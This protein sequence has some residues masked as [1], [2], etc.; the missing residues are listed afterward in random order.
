[1]C[2]GLGKSYGARTILD[3]IDL[4]IDH[5]SCFALLGPNGAGKTTTVEILE[6]Y[7]RP[8][9]GSA[10]VLGL[11]PIKDAAA[12]RPQMGLM[13][14]EGGLYPGIRVSEA[15]RLFAAYYSHPLLPQDA[16]G[17]V[18][19]EDM[20][21]R[22]VRTLSGGEKQRLNLALAL[23]G[24]PQILFLDEPTS[25]MDPQAR[26]AIWSHLRSLEDVTIVLTTHDFQEAERMADRVAI[27]NAGSL[28]ELTNSG[29]LEEAY[30]KM[31]G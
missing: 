20:A 16:L 26:V 29:S 21:G 25:G 6:G 7:R 24:R 23:I 10:K 3:G 13:L 4:T 17:I 5:G 12:L 9:T 30:M 31:L 15:I 19:L 8:D 14:Q 22:K 11:D 28:V 27:L 1:M 2:E 18:G